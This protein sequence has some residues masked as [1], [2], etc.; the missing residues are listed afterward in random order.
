MRDFS[1]K[2]FDPEQTYPGMNRFDCGNEMINTFVRKSLKKRIK[3]HLSQGYVLL[4]PKEAFV[5]FYTLDTFSIG[6]EQFGREERPSGLPPMVP[7]VKLGMLGVEKNLQGMGLG[8]RMLR[9]AMYKVKEIS[10][11]AGC[12]GLYLLAEEDAVSFYRSLGFHPLEDQ[13]PQPMFLDM[14]LI[15]KSI[16]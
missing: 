1:L 11:I 7:V 16:R 8:K 14:T 15:L 3:R 2:K 6:R 5:G 10:E 4:D 13:L 9:D 12:A